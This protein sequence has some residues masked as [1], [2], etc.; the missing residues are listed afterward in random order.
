M[1]RA[2][3]PAVGVLVRG[4]TVVGAASLAA[5]MLWTIADVGLRAVAHRALDGTV[6]I[7]ETLLVLVAFFALADCMARDDTIRVDILDNN[8][9]RRTL[10]WLKLF[11]DVATLAF[12][13]LLVF[14]LTT[15][16]T[17]AWRFGDVKPDVPVP[18]WALLAAIEVAL[19]AAA[20][21]VAARIL[22]SLRDRFA[23][24]RG[25]VTAASRDGGA[26]S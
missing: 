22:R 14:T 8:V 10:G 11:G 4:L 3:H 16:L 9:G 21:V 6:A 7:V 17:D 19:V 18:I 25:R 23:G 2:P 15:P 12:L 20:L 5:M 26:T 1:N 24:S 13:G